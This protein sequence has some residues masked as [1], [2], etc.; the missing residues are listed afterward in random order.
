MV[1][2][3][4]VH[5]KIRDKV[6]DYLNLGFSIEEIA[7][8]LSLPLGTRFVKE[9]VKWYI[10]CIRAKEN[11]KKAIEKYPGL[12]SKAG[13]IA[14]RKHPWIGKKLGKKY[15]PIQGKINAERL[16]G[17][18][19]YFSNMAKKLQQINPDHSKNNM[20]KAH[21]TMKKAGIFNEHQRFAALKCIEKNPTQLK[22][23]SK[24]AHKLYP[25]A[26]LALESR[27]KNYPYK[28]MACSFDSN[29]E[30]LLCE[31]L[32]EGGLIEK[33]LE[34]INVHFIVGKCHIDFFIQNKLF[35]EYHP[36]RKFGR[37]ID[38]E[39]SYFNERRKL[40]DE[41]GF[42]NKPLVVITNLRNI[43]KKI[44]KIKSL[45]QSP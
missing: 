6:E 5:I 44:E 13:K 31:K 22:E 14:Q 45:I 36:L 29:Q 40:L 27:R 11:Q 26:L 15:G 24:K 9:S 30:K 10:Y 3:V 37:I 23:M 7:D 42:K 20:K 34:K 35:L 41:N 16:R 17:N 39:G 1:E 4:G 25:L 12:Y 43:D 38:T 28:F 32:I 19:E 21:E 18:S 2:Q 33:P 8:K